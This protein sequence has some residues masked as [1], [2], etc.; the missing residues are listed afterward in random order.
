MDFY[1]GLK[2]KARE[3]AG[4]EMR[5]KATDVFK[6]TD[7]DMYFGGSWTGNEWGRPSQDMPRG[8]GWGGAH[9]PVYF[10]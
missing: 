2:D 1:D 5:E 3:L 10:L 6:Y 9:A 7:D 8:N 4:V